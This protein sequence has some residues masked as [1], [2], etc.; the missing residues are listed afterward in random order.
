M[1]SARSRFRLQYTARARVCACVLERR[2]V[3]RGGKACL[4][5]RTERLGNSARREEVSR[6]AVCL[7]QLPAQRERERKQ[8]G[9]HYSPTESCRDGRQ[10]G[11]TAHY[12][13][14]FLIKR[15]RTPKSLTITPRY[16]NNPSM[17]FERF[18]HVFKCVITS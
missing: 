2:M 3:A 13:E 12:T 5:R 10:H 18:V 15:K 1:R 6:L 7:H 4:H 14:F 9:S 16:V 17:L 8:S 11:K